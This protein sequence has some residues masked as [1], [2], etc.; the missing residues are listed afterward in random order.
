MFQ[1]S[2]KSAQ[3]HHGRAGSATAVVLLGAGLA[4]AG[5]ARADEGTGFEALGTHAAADASSF[6]MPPARQAAIDNPYLAAALGSMAGWTPA[7]QQGEEAPRAK[8]GAASAA[9]L[10]DA[11][12]ADVAVPDKRSQL[13]AQGTAAPW[14]PVEPERLAALRGGFA[15]AGRQEP[16]V[17]DASAQAGPSAAQ[18]AAGESRMPAA[19]SRMASWKPVAEARLEDL[20]GGFDVAGLQ[21]SFGIERAVFINGALVVSTSLSIPDVSRITADQATRLAAALGVA[22]TAGAAA[23][24][25]VSNALAA[26]PVTGSNGGGSSGS[27]SSSSGASASVAGGPG[28]PMISLPAAAIAAG[29]AA[30]TTNGVLNLIQN[31]PGNTAAAGMLAATPATIIQNTLNNQSIQSLVTINAGVNTLQA[32]RAQVANSTLNNALLHAASQH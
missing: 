25:A 16:D 24:T 17:I 2:S 11:D 6:A 14:T 13:A 19:R 30:V 32:F 12:D 18:A 27:S 31:G 7:S 15:A 22:A 28:A 4:C 29:A 5:H 10:A 9:A 23:G 21:V 20:R 1:T 26:N 8:T 3:R